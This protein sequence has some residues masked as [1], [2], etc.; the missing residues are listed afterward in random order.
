MKILLVMN[1]SGLGGITTAG[2]NFA[3]HLFKE[4][5][6]VEILNMY[7][8]LDHLYK[9]LNKQIPILHLS[10]YAK[11]WNLTPNK[12]KTIRNPFKKIYYLFLGLYKKIKTKNNTW[13]SKVFKKC[14]CDNGYDVAIAYRQ[15]APSY[16][17]VLNNVVANKKMAFVHGELTYMSDISSWKKYMTLFDKVAY[18]S[19]AVKEQFTSAYPELS[20]N[21]CSIHNMLDVDRI[22][23]LSN[24]KNPCEFNKNVKNIVTVARIE[25]TFKQIDW[26][27]QICARLKQK[28]TEPFHWW[29]IGDGPDMQKVK[30]K[31]VEL[32]VEDVITMLGARQNPYC[33]LKDAYFSVLTSKSESFGLVIV[34]SVICKVPVVSTNY[35]A[36]SE[37]LIDGKLGIICEQDIDDVVD[38]INI[39]LKDNQKY[40]ELKKNCERH[41]YTNDKSYQKFLEAVEK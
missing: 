8:G 10:G 12:I 14:C 5:N 19:E 36:L 37:V 24:E 35:P 2:I 9:S 30:D 15:C 13:L 7:D 32:G 39:L 16:F 4:G 17:F 11:N 31:I 41:V 27:P 18:V 6:Q 29:I 23:N 1:E 34:E 22:V 28:D 40:L 38:K 26:I 21:A 20:V 3:N 25:N 33:I